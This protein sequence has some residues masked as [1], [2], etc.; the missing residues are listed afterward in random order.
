MSKQVDSE[1]SSGEH[2]NNKI[3]TQTNN[4]KINKRR[5]GRPATHGLSRTPTY[6]SYREA[7]QRCT[8]SKH[9]D[10][11]QY[12]GRGIEFRFSSPAEIVDEI[13]ERPEG[14]TLDRI[15]F[16]G[17][18]ERKNVQWATPKQ[19]AANRGTPEYFRL[20]AQALSHHPQVETR[21][22]SQKAGKDW[23]M[24]IK[25]INEP[26]RLSQTEASYVEQL[27]AETA[28]PYATFLERGY[29]EKVNYVGLPSLNQPGRRVLVRVGP[30]VRSV[31]SSSM[32]PF[33]LLEG[34]DNIELSANWT[35]DE[36]SMFREVV[37]NSARG[38]EPISLRYSGSIDFN[39]NRIEGRLLAA[40]GRL[41]GLGRQARVVIA[42]DL[43]AALASER[44]EYLLGPEYLFLPDLNV[45][46]SA[47]G[48]NG[49]NRDRLYEVLKE[50]VGQRFPTVV[51][52][53]DVRRLGTKLASIIEYCYG[54][55]DLS[56]IRPLLHHVDSLQTA[57]TDHEANSDI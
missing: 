2:P 51:Y 1:L 11:Q 23:S 21:E 53:E 3:E 10:Y 38:T 44:E 7:K 24:S 17:H 8:N 19:Q 32:T 49:S 31:G 26:R 29:G 54:N 14:K 20:K 34:T 16:D 42:P 13:G 35:Q 28:L 52:V 56:N 12:G 43:A 5:R 6:V 50:R 36:L 4:P 27:R 45:W 39:D 57:N 25:F 30:H 9:P 15:N 48:Q 46:S 18:Y 47:Y 40:A 22:S 33:G 37:S 55:A 41:R